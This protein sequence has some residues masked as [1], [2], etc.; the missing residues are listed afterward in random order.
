M[1]AE[2]I[3]PEKPET[4]VGTA[5]WEGGSVRVQSDDQG[6]R[7][8]LARVFRPT[9]VGLDDPTL[10]DPATGGTA[11]VEPGDLQWF[12][13]VAVVRAPREGLRV[14]FVTETPGGWDPAGAYR[15][16]EA[17]VD[18]REGGGPPRTLGTSRA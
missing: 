14:R 7:E 18:L 1:K 4:V 13:T 9:S 3:R 15:P 16:L 8:A 11:V 10:R 2:F 6:V 12:R 5:L 17:W